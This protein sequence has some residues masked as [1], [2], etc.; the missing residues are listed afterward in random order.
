[1]SPFVITLA[2]IGLMA[3]S[4]ASFAQTRDAQDDALQSYLAKAGE[5][6]A[7]FPYY[8]L[9]R[10]ELVGPDRVVVWTRVNQAWL[11]TV[12]KPCSEL[13][14]TT[15]IALTSSARQ[16]RQRLDH[17][18]VSK[19]KQHCTIMEIRPLLSEKEQPVKS[20]SR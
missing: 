16:V 4:P 6:V 18:I 9:Q 19:G 15:S 7:S 11:L 20:P 5:P 14:Y 12:D 10:W 3:G 2:V 17:V 1:M 8:T 13:E